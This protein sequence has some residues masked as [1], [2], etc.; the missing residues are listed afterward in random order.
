MKKSR[1]ASN[2]SHWYYP[3]EI[4][5]PTGRVRSACGRMIYAKTEANLQNPSCEVC[6]KAM[7]EFNKISDE[8]VGE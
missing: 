3:G 5:Y 2:E 1:F 8:I 4:L 6:R 7:M